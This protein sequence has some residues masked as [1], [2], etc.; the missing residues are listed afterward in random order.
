MSALKHIVV[1]AVLALW[2]PA[3]HAATYGDIEFPRDEHERVDGWNFWW[4]AA[5]LVTE[6][7]NRY[8]V[9]VAFDSLNGLGLTGHQVYPRQG[10]YAG[11]VVTTMDGPE[12]WG[13]DPQT[14]GRYLTKMSNHLPGAS[15]RLL[16][17]TVDMADGGREIGRWERTTLAREAYRLRL[18]NKAARVHPSGE[19]VRLL[20]DLEADM[21]SPPLLA[22]G[23]GRWW[24]G[25]PDD[26]SYPSRS[27]QYMQ[28]AQRLTGTLALEQPDGSVL[29]ETVDPDASTLLMVREY[30]ATPEDLPA[31]LAVAQATQMHP[32]YVSYYEGGMPW[33]LLFID[34]RN[35]AQLMVAVLAFHETRKETGTPI[36]PGDQAT[37]K[38]LATL[39][40]PSGESVPLN[41][42][43]RLEHLSYK[44]SVGRVPTFWVAVKGIWTQA[45]EYRV[46]HPGGPAAL[47][48]GG[49]VEVPAFD[50]GVTPQLDVSEPPVDARG[51]GPT[52]RIPYLADGSY[53][54]CPVHGF[55]WSELIIQWR[56]REDANP[57]WTGGD[58]PPVPAACGEPVG[59]RRPPAGELDPPH[60]ERPPDPTPD[61][62]CS[63]YGPTVPTCEYTA[64]TAA[65]ISGY[66]SE[67]GGWTATVTSPEKPLPVV[68]RSHGGQELYACGTIRKGDRVRLTAREG[69][70]VFV[71][72]PGIC[73]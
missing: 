27:Y 4:G 9:G 23:T 69:S 68:V 19:H 24:Y 59:E 22:G 6:S 46:S 34:L 65:G 35:G 10:P 11:R 25:I 51:N 49:T 31:G 55:G 32:R 38:L 53:D 17:T 63:A 12:E 48:G 54:G 62:G 58:P 18:D 67:P 30:D 2:A 1:M 56:G 33:E 5:D 42:A 71:G 14:F 29:R 64:G 50:L 66:G 60:T 3:A 61:E 43:V 44:T 37:Y 47:P 57:W 15:E 7:G 26:H 20:V 73:F 36:L 39:R 21:H 16:G 70:G 40:L 52:Q 13:H 45:W 72:N 8:S 41:D 28:A